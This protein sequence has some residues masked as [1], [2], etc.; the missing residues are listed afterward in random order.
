MENGSLKTQFG[1]KWIINKMLI[2]EIGVNHLGQK[3]IINS[4][5]KKL[6]NSDVDGITFQILEQNKL[7]KLNII[8]F[9]NDFYEEK[10][11]QIK[12][13]KKKIGIAINDINKIKF[14][15]NQKIDFWKV[16][17]VDFY[18][19][20]LIQKLIKTEKPIYLSTGFSSFKEIIKTSRIS[21]YINFIHTVLSH[22]IEDANLSAMKI[23]KNHLGKKISFG[24]HCSDTNI[25]YASIFYEP[26]LIFFY[27]KR[28][29][30]K[31]IYDNKHAIELSN[32][33]DM[34]K[35]IKHL[36]KAIGNSRKRKISLKNPTK[37]IK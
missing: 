33:N 24:L 9:T 31:K 7:K 32:L 27:V 15:N 11:S 14:F 36:K 30:L 26:N 13:S 12:K 21:K 29:H 2:A 18:N 8:E 20:N 35:R 3:K 17:S 22:K 16:L 4:F 25:I 10:I 6:I 23:L 28:S 34:I 1:N 37:K 5:L 19:K